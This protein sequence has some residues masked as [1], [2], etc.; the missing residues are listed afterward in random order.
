MK[1][2]TINLYSFDEL[3]K[4]GQQSALENYRD[5]NVDHEWWDYVYEWF[6]EEYGNTF[7]IERIYFSGFSSQGDGACFI[8]SGISKDLLNEAIDSLNIR[9]LF[10]KVLKA[11]IDISAECNHSSRYYHEK[12][13]RHSFES[14][15]L[16]R[17]NLDELIDENLSLIEEY[18]E[19]RYESACNDLYCRL[20][21]EYEYLT[22]DEEVVETIKLNDYYFNENGVI[23]S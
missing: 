5:I 9:P 13:V 8:Y 12:S 19:D 16:D 17:T 18:I 6:H 7:D 11:N 15:L 1:T 21:N 4:E 14:C 22:S 3:S 10:K 2:K 20:Q 23:E